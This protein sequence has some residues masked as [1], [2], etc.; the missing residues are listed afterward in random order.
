MGAVDPAVGRLVQPDEDVLVGLP[1]GTILIAPPEPLPQV[2]DGPFHLA[3]HPGAVGSAQKRLEAVMMREGEHLGVED[4]LPLRVPPDHD[5]LHVDVEDLG[6]NAA[7]I[8]EAPDVAVQE[9]LQRA[10]FD[11]LDVIGP[12]EAQNQ[13]KGEDLADPPTGFV[14]LEFAAADDKYPWRSPGCSS[15]FGAWLGFPCIPPW[16]SWVSPS[17][18]EETIPSV[19]SP[20]G[21]LFNPI[22][23]TLFHARRHR[24]LQRRA[25][26]LRD[27]EYLRLKILT[28]MLPAI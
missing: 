14:H 27:E 3:L 18:P 8:P 6:R 22:S 25:Y 5:V 1:D 16:R 28:C 15:R 19:Q 17:L 4:G 20:G 7:Q 2:I 11:E 12:A 13:D 21:T 26:G 9:G 10:V 23:G 24:V